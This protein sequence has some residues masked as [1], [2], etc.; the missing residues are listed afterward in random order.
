VGRVDRSFQRD[1]RAKPARPGGGAASDALVTV[2]KWV[3]TCRPV[4][5]EGRT[6]EARTSWRRR[7]KPRL[8]DD[9]F[10]KRN[11]DRLRPR[12]R[13]ELGQD[14]ADVALDGFL[15]DVE[16]GGYVL[17][18]H[19]VREQLQD[20]ALAPGQHVVLALAGQERRH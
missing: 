9:R 4:I 12:V 17:V 5:S 8:V 14:V 11:R 18:R 2:S 20:L 10:A 16:L 7:P 3:R 1:A 13:L 19:P 15:A 6:G